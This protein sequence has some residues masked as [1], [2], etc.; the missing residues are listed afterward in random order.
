MPEPGFPGL[1][2]RSGP[3][4]ARR[5]C[6]APLQSLARPKAPRL[7]RG[8]FL[9]ASV[10]GFYRRLLFTSK[11][12][13]NRGLRTALLDLFKN[14]PVLS[15]VSRNLPHMAANSGIYFYGKIAC[16]TRVSQA[17]S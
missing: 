14:L 10:P 5:G 8:N 12:F 16:E 13:A 15:Q 2:C 11:P 1:R 3:A 17:A 7:R 9:P 4:A 6:Y